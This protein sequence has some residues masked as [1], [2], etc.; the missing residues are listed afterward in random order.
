MTDMLNRISTLLLSLVLGAFVLA[1]AAH[2][3]KIG[4]TNQEA[5]LANMPEMQQVQRQLQQAA[6][7]QRKELQREQQRL[8]KKMKQY[9]Q[10]QSL[11][12]DSARSA[13][14]QELRQLQ[15]ELQQS[16]RQRQQELRQREQELMQPLLEDLQSAIDSVAASRDIDVVLRTQALLYVDQQSGSVVDITQDVAQGLGIELQQTPSEPSPSVQPS[17]TPTGPGGGQ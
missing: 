5:I 6:Q 8:Q 10:R 14:Q 16:Q 12:S 13:R 9:Q 17:G 15:S 3:Q 7:Q 2:A 11:L 4:Y 1:P